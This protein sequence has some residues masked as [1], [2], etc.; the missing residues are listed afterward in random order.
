MKNPWKEHQ[1]EVKWILNYLRGTSQVT[2]VLEVLA[3]MK[4]DNVDS[5]IQFIRLMEEALHIM[6]CC[7][8]NFPLDIKQGKHQS[9]GLLPCLQQKL[10]MLAKKAVKNSFGQVTKRSITYFKVKVAVQFYLAKN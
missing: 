8:V 7:L 6:D 9:T 10:H 3:L 1:Q 5:N 2:Y 4:K